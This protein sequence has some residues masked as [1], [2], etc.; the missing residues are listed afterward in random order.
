MI[1]P[2]HVKADFGK[3]LKAEMKTGASKHNLNKAVFTE[4]FQDKILGPDMRDQNTV[5][6]I[7]SIKD[8]KWSQ[9]K[10]IYF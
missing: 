7:V 2:T 1:C 6:R 8:H 9:L 3:T 5:R 4:N 10:L